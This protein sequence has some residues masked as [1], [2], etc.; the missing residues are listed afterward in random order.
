VE[1]TAFIKSNERDSTAVTNYTNVYVKNFSSDW[2]EDKVKEVFGAYGT[3]TSAM[4]NSDA[5]GRK[6]AFVNFETTEAAQKCVEEMNDK[7]M[8]TDEEKKKAE[9]DA[10]APEFEK[11][12]VGR[13]QTKAERAREFRAQGAANDA[14][15]P[16]AAGVNLYIKNLDEEADDES[17]K[18]LFEPFGTV[19]SVVAMKDEKGKCKGFGFI[20]FTAP[21]DATKA[22][23]EMHLKVVKGKPLYVGLAEKKDQRA[24]RLRSR[25]T[26]GGPG[27]GGKGDKGGKGGKGGGYG[28]Q[29]MGGMPQQ[30][31]GGPM[32][33]G[34]GGPMMGGPM[35]GMPQQMGGKG[36][37]MGGQMMG[38]P[39]MGQQQ[40]MMQMMQQ[41]GQMQMMQQ[42]GQMQ[43]GMP[44]MMGGKG[45]MPG[46][47]GMNPMQMMQK[48]GMPPM[49]QMPQQQAKGG[50]PPM[51]Q[52]PQQQQAPTGGA[53]LN[54][55]A[56]AAAPPAVQKQMIGEK[57]Y[58]MIAKVHPDMAGK[59]TGMM[60]E[61]DNSEL[62]MLLES[63][64]QFTAKV[65][66]ALIVLTK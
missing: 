5:K 22:V 50:M 42:K 26:A 8:R 55:A 24:E 51:Q 63:P 7:D 30:M 6:F 31:M 61:M 49:Q 4:V 1:V 38:N 41:K 34:M 52:Q 10:D 29:M 14:S 58:P 66:E 37:M 39:M 45:P 46:M 28:G 40:Q 62:L 54:A 25:Y 44:G 56:L 17:L 23:T 43:G 53:G 65:N 2:D 47:P 60:L 57:L 48:G 20:S 9:E 21:D 13:A 64:A 59:V 16:S 33:G 3:I 27:K 36:P 15:K 32:M 18:A 11:L 35:M 12:Y 19:S